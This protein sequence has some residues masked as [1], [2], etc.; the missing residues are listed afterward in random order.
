MVFIFTA[1]LYKP[2]VFFSRQIEICIVHA[3]RLK[4]MFFQILIKGFTGPYLNKVTKHIHIQSVGPS[5]AWLVGK[6][7]L[8]QVFHL[9]AYYILVASKS[10]CN[11][12][13]GIYS[14]H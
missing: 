13:F 6:R 3:Q 12:C 8:S 1:D 7:Q 9:I 14:P 11:A 2:A 4:E 5:F 10:R